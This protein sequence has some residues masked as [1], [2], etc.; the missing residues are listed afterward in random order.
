[1]AKVK[2]SSTVRD[3]WL[4]K[5]ANFCYFTAFAQ[6]LVRAPGTSQNP[7]TFT[8]VLITLTTTAT[9]NPLP[10]TLTT[11]LG[12]KCHPKAREREL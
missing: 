5:K 8:D 10:T 6:K 2:D 3:F 7:S 11:P 1:M 9:T 4:H 12:T